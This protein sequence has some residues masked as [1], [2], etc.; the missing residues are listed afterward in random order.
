MEMNELKKRM[1][2][3]VSALKTEFN[4]L[5]TGRASTDLLSAVTV[6]AYGSRMPLNQVGTVNVTDPRTLS[7]QVWDKGLVDAAEKA[8]RE[9]GLGLNPSSDGNVI[10]VPMP[11]LNEERRKEL[12]KVARKYAEDSRVAVR[13]V[14]RDGMDEVKKLQKDGDISEDEAHRM[15]DDIQKL[16]DTVTKEVDSLLDKKE[17]DI[18][19]V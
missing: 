13:N 14:R 16:T 17:Q 5:R 11:E 1:D 6:E 2:G 18:L 9:A 3:A 19:Q 12:I 4:G 15:S 10:R 8:I 7:V